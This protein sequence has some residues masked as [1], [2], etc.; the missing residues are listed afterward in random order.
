MTKRD[1]AALVAR[2]ELRKARNARRKA[3][4]KLDRLRD[5]IERIVCD[6]DDERAEFVV[7]AT[8]ACWDG[9]EVD[10]FD[11]HL[12]RHQVEWPALAAAKKLANEINEIE[13]SQYC[14]APIN[15]RTYQQ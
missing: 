12:G 10:S 8:V 1:K 13:R 7:G 5:A 9:D 15:G 3:Q 2:L 6:T 4:R 14:A 11:V